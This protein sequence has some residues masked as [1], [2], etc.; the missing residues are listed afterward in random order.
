[1]GSSRNKKIKFFI[2]IVIS[3]LLYYSSIFRLLK[4]IKRKKPTVLCYH[5]IVEDFY[6][7]S[8]YSQSGLLVS[9]DSFS[10]QMDFIKKN[11]NVI[12][13]DDFVKYLDGK[14]RLPDYSLLITFDDG[15]K[16]NYSIA[17]NILRQHEVP[18]T[19]FIV[20]DFADSRRCPSWE[21][22]RPVGQKLMLSWEEIIEMSKD[23]IS[24]G[25]HTKTHPV[26]NK[27]QLE[28]EYYEEIPES[29]QIIEN[30]IKKEI[31]TFAYP[32]GTYNLEAMEYL[33]RS[34]FKCAFTLNEQNNK[35]TMSEYKRFTIGRI[36]INEGMYRFGNGKSHMPIFACGLL[37]FWKSQK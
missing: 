29:K 25:A 5:R 16:D 13:M 19:I 31:S 36:P 34:G 30:N 4:F 18:A 27:Q 21:N 12:S 11:H 6:E 9:K 23:S 7:E 1:M 33:Q 10:K 26:Y 22:E 14:A 32:E 37:N 17:Y 15:Y 20:T 2:K 28:Q 3:S 8:K 24:F 35:D